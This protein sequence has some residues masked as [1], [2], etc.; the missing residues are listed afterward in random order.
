VAEKGLKYYD[1]DNAQFC[2]H[3]LSSPYIMNPDQKIFDI[4]REKV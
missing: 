4:L 3:I 2:G 1:T